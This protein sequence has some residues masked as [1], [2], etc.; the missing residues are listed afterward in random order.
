MNHSIRMHVDGSAAEILGGIWTDAGGANNVLDQLLLKMRGP[1]MPSVFRIEDMATITT[2]ATGL[3]AAQFAQIRGMAQQQVSVDS[4][5]AQAAFASE[6]YQRL[7]DAPVIDESRLLAYYKTKDARWVQLHTG[8][9][10]HRDGHLQ[11]LKC[12]ADAGADEVAAA[13]S[14]WQAQELED[15]MAQRMLPGVKMRS[16]EEWTASPQGQAVA[17]LPLLEIIKIGDAPVLEIEPGDRPLS[18]VRV[19]DMTKVIAGPVCGRTLA[20][21]GAQV[22][23]VHAPRLPFSRPLVIDTG[24]GKRSCHLDLLQADDKT[25]FTEL[26]GGAHVMTQGYRPGAIAAHGFAPQQVAALR[27]GIVCL[28]LCAWS[29]QGPWAQR[30]GF[31]SLVQMASGI[32]AAGAQALK[33]DAPGPLP[34]QALDHSTGY[35]AAFGV[36]MALAHQQRQGG[37]WHVRVSLAQS[38]EWL[39][40]LGCADTLSLNTPDAS[41]L[42][43][44]M[45]A[46]QTSFGHATFIRPVAQ[47]ENT[48]GYWARGSVPLGH[49]PA[50]WLASG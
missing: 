45:G 44:L 8:F 20:E 48:P 30:R 6:R 34:C 24:R 9:A 5:H 11:L 49:D 14:R 37:S 21:H 47:L 33:Q 13:V 1:L 10:H 29:H 22:M 27:P 16:R 28:S 19:L 38:S 23:R 3:G 41:E 35:L 25:R 40:R 17:R 4:R 50:Q 39:N 18:G 42:S 2:A 46:A 32:A 36:L 43:D 7:D 12:A 31:D 26:L 15:A